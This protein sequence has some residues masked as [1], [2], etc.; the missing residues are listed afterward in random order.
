M[1][2]DF[3][4]FLWRTRQ[5]D[6]THLTTTDG[7]P[8]EILDFG[9][10][11]ALDSGA[12]FQ[13]VKLKIGDW[14][15]FGSVEMHVR[16]SDWLAH[17]HQTDAAFGSVIL[18][19][20][21]END[22]EI[23]RISNFRF[24]EISN[25]KFQGI[26]N[27]K[28]QE[29]PNSKF[30]DMSDADSEIWNLESE[31]NNSPK[32]PCLAL[33]NRIP[34]G[35][36]KK[37]W[38]MLHN[39]DWIPCQSHIHQVSDLTKNK[40]LERLAVERLERKSAAI[41]VALTQNKDDWEETFWQ[42]TARYFGSKV[43]AEPMEMLARSLPHRTLAKHKNQLF[44]IEA[45]LFGQAGFLEKDF[46]DDYLIRL[47]KE[48]QFL[49]NKHNLIQAV[50][51]AAWKYGRL[52]PPSFP[53][54]RLAQLAALIHR[55][56]HLFSKIIDNQDISALP[57]LFEVE[58]SDYWHNHFVFDTPSVSSPKRLGSDTIDVILIN[59]I[60]P[61]LYLYGKLR[62]DESLKDRSLLVLEKVKPEKNTLIDGWKTLGF[63]IPSAAD[64][65]AL[66]QLKTTYCD[67]KK[68]AACAIGNAILKA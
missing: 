50:P 4:H 9:N 29:I 3:L 52:R 5:F 13:N 49:K 16:A 2:E 33:K 62:G 15:W 38:A 60:A 66:I 32:I 30:Q 26:P 48:Y 7:E 19:V 59:N 63:T 65:Q 11:N 24:Q 42:F 67:L 1:R 25:S 39:A 6:T 53:T 37:Y 68:C 58:V 61:F 56:L 34:E 45:L 41:Q 23:P 47:K 57:A 14:T 40:W 35:I 54:I 31:I 55:S 10:Y 43:N 51:L 36:F 8:I 64:T 28:F 12:D 21:F 27:S 22:V 46:A 17:G 18:H 20:V 44:Q